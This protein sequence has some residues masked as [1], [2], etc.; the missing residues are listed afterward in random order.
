MER[1]LLCQLASTNT[2]RGLC[3]HLNSIRKEAMQTLA[4]RIP[5]TTKCTEVKVVDLISLS[6]LFVRRPQIS[7]WVQLFRDCWW[8]IHFFSQ[9]SSYICAPVL[10]VVV[11][12]LSLMTCHLSSL[13]EASMTDQSAQSCSTAEQLC[14]WRTLFPELAISVA[15]LYSCNTSCSLCSIEYWCVGLCYVNFFSFFMNLKLL[16][17]V[18]VGRVTTV[19]LIMSN[20]EA[21]L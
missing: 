15:I 18:G 10:Q 9:C 3:L 7:L 1:A 11:P 19:S 5:F 13:R 4:F 20:T 14:I 21:L 16:G 6:S 2:E 12:S 17:N 8:K